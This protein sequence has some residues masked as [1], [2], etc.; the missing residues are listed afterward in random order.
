[1]ATSVTVVHPASAMRAD[2]LSTTL[3]LLGRAAGDAFLAAHDPDA[4]AL[5]L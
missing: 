2:G 1:G 5:W 4:T 3:F